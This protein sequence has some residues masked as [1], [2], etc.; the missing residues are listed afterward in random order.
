MRKKYLLAVHSIRFLIVGFLR[1]T[2]KSLF[3]PHSFGYFHFH[4]FL[5]S[6]LFSLSKNAIT[7]RWK[8]PKSRIFILILL[9]PNL[10]NAENPLFLPQK[11]S[12]SQVQFHFSNLKLTF[13][14]SKDRDKIRIPYFKLLD[15][16]DS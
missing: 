5:A 2:I 10:Q 4:P 11:P 12:N 1:S 16:T 3:Y 14:E 9:N 6:H 15:G 7:F 8:T 13:F